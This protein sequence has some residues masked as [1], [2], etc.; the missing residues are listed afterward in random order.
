MPGY[1][2]VSTIKLLPLFVCLR[3]KNWLVK[4]NVDVS[5][6]GVSSINLL[7]VFFIRLTNMLVNV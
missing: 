3:I 7:T 4:M 5:Y 6:S 1:I 2:V